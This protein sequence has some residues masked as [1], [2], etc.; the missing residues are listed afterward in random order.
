[1]IYI[2]SPS[3]VASPPGIENLD[4]LETVL[5]SQSG[6]IPEAT[7]ELRVVIDMVKASL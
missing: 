6:H 5:A 4:L 3:G 1:M 7:E 2:M